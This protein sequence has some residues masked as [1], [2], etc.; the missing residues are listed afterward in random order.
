MSNDEN[1]K[2]FYW[3]KLKTDF[4]ENEA[5]DFLLS[6]KDGSQY[7]ALYLKLCT[8]TANTNGKLATQIG[9]MTIPYNVE[10]IARDTKFF[11][12]DTVRVALDLF[13]NLGLIC[14]S[15]SESNVLQI[16][17]YDDMIGSETKWAQKKRIFRKKQQ[18]LEYSEGQ[19]KDNVLGQSE[20]HSEGH[21]LGQKK[22][23]VRQ[24]SRVKSL[25]SRD[26]SLE[27][28]NSQ[29]SQSDYNARA[30]ADACVVTNP[31]LSD[32]QNYIQKNKL[33]VDGDFFWNYY[34]DKHWMTGNDHI[35][36]WKS[37]LRSWHRKEKHPAQEKVQLDEK[38]YV[39]PCTKAQ[40]ELDAECAELRQK[41]A[42]GE[43]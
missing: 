4:F 27:T 12:V 1:S 10:K 25:E 8:M 35:R 29:S 21:A 40:Q 20:G 3:I 26:K 24:E 5:I 7:I 9:E 43:L 33:N 36:D 23:N 14:E 30:C 28:R 34:Q 15:E 32:V 17:G 41:L 39:K 16:S 2:K 38:F 13:K 22:D 37:L 31:T 11:T 18:V 6:Q 42:N 19:K